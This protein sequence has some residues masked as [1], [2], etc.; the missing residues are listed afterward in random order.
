MFD[1]L[2]NYA[3]CVVRRGAREKGRGIII[4]RLPTIEQAQKMAKELSNES[5]HYFYWA[6][7][8]GEYKPELRK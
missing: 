3:F 4:K 5:K 2:N 7:L 1:L 8:L 6:M